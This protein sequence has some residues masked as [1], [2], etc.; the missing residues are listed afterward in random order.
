[1]KSLSYGLILIS[2]VSIA[3]KEDK[4]VKPTHNWTKQQSI[5][6]NSGFSEEEED[7]IN[8][9]LKRRPDW[10][11]TKTGT[12]LRYFIYNK[13][14]SKDSVFVGDQVVVSFSISLLDGTECY[15]SS[16]KG[17]ETFVVDKTD[18]ESGLHEAIKYL[19]LGDKARLILPSHLAHGLIGDQDKIP[20]LET[21]VYDI[22]LL[23]II[24]KDEN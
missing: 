12:G 3:C 11:M 2:L 21:V 16:K 19:K 5:Q 4:N 24:S 23:N 15:N 8:A 22:H 7:A 14:E 10:K 9:Y 17:P 13:S 18:I 6:M 20:P 1:M